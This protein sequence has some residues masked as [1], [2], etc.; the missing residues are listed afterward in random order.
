LL[1][2][3]DLGLAARWNAKEYFATFCMVADKELQFTQYK[4]VQHAYL[5]CSVVLCC[6]LDYYHAHKEDMQAIGLLDRVIPLVF[7][8]SRETR[9]EYQTYQEKC[10]VMDET[11]TPRQPEVIKPGRMKSDIIASHDVDP[12]LLR[13]LQRISQYLTNEE[14]SELIEAAHTNGK[15]EI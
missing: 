5:A 2:N 4:Q 3:D 8:L 1:I 11:C 7:G 14:T 15:Y 9:R 10:N 13:N 12:R 6:T